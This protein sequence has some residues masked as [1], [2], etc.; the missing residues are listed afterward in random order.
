MPLL[1]RRLK[2]FSLIQ[3]LKVIS[4][5]SSLIGG[6]SLIS[7]SSAGLSFRHAQLPAENLCTENLT[8]FLKLLPCK[9]LSGLSALMKP[10]VLLAHEWHAMG[11]DYVDHAGMTT[12]GL[13]WEA[14]VDLT[15]GKVEDAKN[16]GKPLYRIVI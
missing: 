16:L 14:V 8:P 3:T 13:R 9:G 12:L 10:Y 15:K 2:T 1:P 7:T 5:P 11:V 4:V 6:P